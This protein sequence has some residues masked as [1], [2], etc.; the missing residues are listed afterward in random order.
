MIR[1][2]CLTGASTIHELRAKISELT[3]I[4]FNSL[5]ILKGYPPKPIDSSND[6]T[7]ACFSIKDGE[8]LTIEESQSTSSN[9][10][11][12]YE[13]QTKSTKEVTETKASKTDTTK[14]SSMD[15][16]VLLR[17]VVPANNSCLFTS[18]FFV[19]ENGKFDLDCQK[20]MREI[21]AK[22]VKNDPV[23]FNEAIL[24]KKNSEYCS[25]IRNSSSWGG[26]IEVMI[27]SKYY[28]VEICVV[29]IRT[30]R[31]DRFGEDK[32]Y[33]NRV[34]I[35]YDGIHFDPLYLQ[36]GNGSDITKIKT[37]FTKTEDFVMVQAMEMA[38][39][40]KQ[41]RQYTDV[42]NFKLKCLVCQQ[43]L[44]GQKAAQEHA[45]KTLHTNFGEI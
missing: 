3:G 24:G 41:A 1:I 13:S 7:L 31:I 12:L 35:I 43:P 16:G 17:K 34:F 45:E 23:E 19:M 8:L 18:V 30:A 9:S 27:F 29:D 37:K 15:K 33:P 11:S 10:P 28:G 42:H 2:E 32:N 39:E 20:G 40:A 44:A 14:S 38:N 5:K 36:L 25:W 22:T 21:I 6:K 4:D 26:S